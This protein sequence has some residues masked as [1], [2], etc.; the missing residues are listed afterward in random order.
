MR[1]ELESFCL[2]LQP[3]WRCYLLLQTDKGPFSSFFP[4]P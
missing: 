4:F 3:F 1:K 2:V